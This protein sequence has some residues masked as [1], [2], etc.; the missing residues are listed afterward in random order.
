MQEGTYDRK[1][2]FASKYIAEGKARAKAEARLKGEAEGRIEGAIEILLVV[3]EARG[4]DVDE[5]LRR[6]ITDCRD[7]QQLRMWVRRVAVAQTIDEV[8]A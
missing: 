2:D 4:F 1:S 7:L 8:F 5:E 6:R 3:L